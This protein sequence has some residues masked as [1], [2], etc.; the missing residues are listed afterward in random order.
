MDRSNTLCLV[1][2]LSKKTQ[3]D[4]GQAAMTESDKNVALLM[5]VLVSMIFSVISKPEEM[6][7]PWSKV[8]I[9]SLSTYL[10]T[11]SF[12]DLTTH[13]II[14]LPDLTF[15]VIPWHSHKTLG[16]GFR[17]INNNEISFLAITPAPCNK[18][19]IALIIRQ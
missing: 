12:K 8:Y 7:S 9:K 19:K 1:G 18:V 4:C 6:I 11:T 16:I 15:Y 2:N 13:N 17:K 10:I 5:P 14:H 3:K